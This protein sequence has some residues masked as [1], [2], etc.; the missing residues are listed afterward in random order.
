VAGVL[1]ARRA[2]AGV[3]TA[4]A[5]LAC[6]G[7]ADAAGETMPG[8][9]AADGTWPGGRVPGGTAGGGNWPSA[10]DFPS[11]FAREVP[12]SV[13]WPGSLDRVLRG[14]PIVSAGKAGAV[15]AT[16]PPDTAVAGASFRVALAG[17]SVASPPG[18][19]PGGAAM[20][21]PGRVSWPS[22]PIRSAPTLEVTTV[23]EALPEPSGPFAR[24]SKPSSL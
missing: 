3:L 6:G 24:L 14:A 12:G 11:A 10:G 18:A 20:M 5:L 8:V 23:G 1:L 17:A 4:G 19:R 16:A 13:P 7:A 2:S 9:T 15:S 21:S 22:S